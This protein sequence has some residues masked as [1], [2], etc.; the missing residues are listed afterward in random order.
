MGTITDTSGH[1][2][3][4]NIPDGSYH[5]R[6]SS[7]VYNDFD[8]KIILKK[9]CHIQLNIQLTPRET[10][11]NEIVLTG[12]SRGATIKENPVS[13]TTVSSKAIDLTTAGNIIDVLVK[14]VPGLNAVKTGPNISKPFIRGLGYN[15]VLTLYDGIRQEGQQWGDEHG[16]EVDAYNIE[17]AEIIKGPA[18][19]MFGSDAEAGV[20]SLFP[21]IPAYRDKKIH[22]RILSEYQNNNNL[23]GNAID[24]NYSD[25]HFSI[26]ANGSYRLAKN[27]RNR[28]DGRVY[29]TNF[30][31]KNLSLFTGYRSA[32]GF[33]HLAFTLYDNLQGIPDG[34]RDSLTRKFTKQ[35]YEGNS[36]DIKNRPIVSDEELNSYELSPLHQHIQHYR[37]YTQ[38]NYAMGK[39]NMNFIAGLQQNIRREYNHPTA[40]LQPGMHVRL[41]TINYGLRYNFPKS[42]SFE[43]TAGINGMAQNNKSINATDFPIPDYNLFDGGIYL[44]VKWKP[45]ARNGIK[46]KWTVS[47]GIRYDIRRIS[48]DNFYVRKSPVTHFDERV[49]IPDTAGAALQFPAY[50]KT[51]SGVSASMGTTHELSKSVS[52]KANVGRGYRAPNMTEIASNGLDPGA[53]IIYL[54]NRNFHPEFSLQEDLGVIISTRKFSGDFS[55]FNNNIQNY[56]YLSLQTDAEG[57]PLTD[58]QGNKTYQYQQSSAQLYGMEAWSSWQPLRNCMFNN[59]ISLIYGFNRGRPFKHTGNNGEYLPLI[60]PVKILSNASYKVTSGIFSFTPKVEAEI[61]AAQTR[62]LALNNT[63]TYTRGYALFNAGIAT[64]IQYSPDHSIEIQLQAS[65]VFNKACQSNLSRLKYFEYYE[66]S[67]SGHLGIYNMGRNMCLKVIA[68]F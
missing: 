62:F 27:Y 4:L 16:I 50:G 38:S 47:G 6:V 20:V 39:G 43:T 1:F 61:N 10:V 45:T 19:L 34:S 35:I 13:I 26:S 5:L 14:N 30:R 37:I 25:K 11:L 40:P 3:L 2:I 54:G 31:E 48:F 51:F 59:S 53:H 52:L 58:A 12:I 46:D 28:V 8:K 41:N 64:E 68:T 18:S 21:Y 33:T 7:S 36:D 57:R 65:N 63:E 42:G 49:A 56:I 22:G 9:S 24:L 66:S 67:P 23:A 15:R 32:K 55:I 60:P 17:R 44:Y 29:N